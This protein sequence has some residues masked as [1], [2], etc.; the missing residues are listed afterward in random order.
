MT[1]LYF[2]R[3][4]LPVHLQVEDVLHHVFELI[5]VLCARCPRRLVYLFVS[6]RLTGR[7]VAGAGVGEDML[8]SNLWVSDSKDKLEQIHF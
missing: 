8:S 4:N 2:D 6:Q 3:S 7:A 1:L 5:L